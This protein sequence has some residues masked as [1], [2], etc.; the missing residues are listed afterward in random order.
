MTRGA[1]Y[2]ANGAERLSRNDWYRLQRSLEIALQLRGAS[3]SATAAGAEGGE[4]SAQEGPLLTGTRTKLLPAD[5]DMRTLYFDL[6][7]LE[8]EER[9]A[10]LDAEFVV[11]VSPL[12]HQASLRSGHIETFV[13]YATAVIAVSLLV[14][15]FF[16][17]NRGRNWLDHADEM[18]GR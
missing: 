6:A 1:S 10:S 8:R 4:D 11:R 16:L 3:A 12:L 9:S 14:Y 17:D 18:A 5:I 15:V 2:D 7:W 13:I